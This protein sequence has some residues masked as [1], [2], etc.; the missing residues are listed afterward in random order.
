M[1][2]PVTG[3]K[4]EATS[5]MQTYTHAD[6][7]RGATR[8]KKDEKI[9]T[10]TGKELWHVDKKKLGNI[11][12]NP[13]KAL[14]SARLV[15]D[16]DGGRITGF[17]IASIK[18]NSPLKQ[19]GLKPGD[20]LRQVN[21]KQVDSVDTALKLLTQLR[22]ASHIGVDIERKGKPYSLDYSLN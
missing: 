16:L 2:L 10:Q 21:G 9:A 7:S 14:Q 11:L 4:S 18:P 6:Q 1:F 22:S 19:L 3:S 8:D 13:G 15:P 20:V 12:D 17:R 5:R